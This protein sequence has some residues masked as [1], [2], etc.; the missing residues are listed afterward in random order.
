MLHGPFASNVP[1]CAQT[2]GMRW[3]SSLSSWCRRSTPAARAAAG[4]HAP[5]P[6][7]DDGRTKPQPHT[8]RTAPR[9][10]Q[11]YSCRVVL[12][13]R[14]AFTTFVMASRAN[15]WVI[16]VLVRIV[17]YIWLVLGERGLWWRFSMQNWTL[18]SLW[19]RFII[20]IWCG[21]TIWYGIILCSIVVLIINWGLLYAH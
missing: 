7:S 16:L 3:G 1:S 17:W 2:W 14:H 18:D 20:I 6:R 15:Y 12:L 19:S 10:S 5:H 11:N 13:Q 9:P 8:S 4:T 21:I